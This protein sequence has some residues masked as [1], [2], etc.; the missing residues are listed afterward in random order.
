MTHWHILVFLFFL[1]HWQYGW[2]QQTFSPAA[3]PLAVRSPYLS[4]WQFTTNGSTIGS[5]AMTSNQ[6]LSTNLISRVHSRASYNASAGVFPLSYNSTSGTT[7]L[8]AAS[9]A[10]GAMYAP[11]A[12]KFVY[13]KCSFSM[14][15][16][17]FLIG[18]A[19]INQITVDPQFAPPRTGISM[20]SKI[21]LGCDVG[22]ILL[23]IISAIYLTLTPFNPTGPILTGATPLDAE[24]QTDQQQPMTPVPVGGLSSE[25]FAQ[26]SRSQPTVG[27]TLGHT[28]VPSNPIALTLTDVAPLNTGTQPAAPV[29]VGLY[30]EFAQL[31]SRSQPTDGQTLMPFN[32]T[33][34]TLT[35]AA[36]LDTRPQTDQQ[37]VATANNLWHLSLSTFQQGACAAALAFQIH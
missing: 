9:P 20:A 6:D 11:L 18:R 7:I 5:K 3:I 1:V 23:V 34:P 37:Q 24:P 27:Q 8:G 16:L 26:L 17:L 21:A 30:S 10:Q 32:P 33:G 15:D 35:G 28:L 31:H 13:N 12:L 2:A 25:G 19:P 36:S 14:S 4:C 29:P 22:V